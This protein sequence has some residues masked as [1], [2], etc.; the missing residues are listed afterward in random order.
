MKMA[1]SMTATKITGIEIDLNT[2]SMIKNTAPIEIALTTLKSLS[3]ICIKSFVHGASPI[4]MASGS[5]VLIIL[6]NV[7]HWALTSSD[8][9]LYSD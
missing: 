8:A 2:N 6:F 1:N 7:S 4:S 3:V 9:T 5:Y